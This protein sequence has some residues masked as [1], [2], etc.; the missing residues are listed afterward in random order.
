VDETT[1]LTRI[2][3]VEHPAAPVN[4]ICPT[5]ISTI[6][7]PVE[8]ASGSRRAIVAEADGYLG[9]AAAEQFGTPLASGDEHTQVV[10]AD[11]AAGV[12]TDDAVVLTISGELDVVTAPTVAGHIE[13]HFA[14]R[15]ADDN[16]LLV[17]DL[18][19]VT[20]LASAGLAVLASTSALA[21]RHNAEVRLVV[22]SRVVLRPLTLTGLDK[23]LTIAPDLATA[24]VRD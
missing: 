24:M 10:T 21:T 5:Y 6:D 16:R 2:R 12:E 8:D 3:A 9:S 15:A 14:D 1:T 19:E 4:D 22:N 11:V 18:S 20:F 13:R 7:N 23:A 17:L